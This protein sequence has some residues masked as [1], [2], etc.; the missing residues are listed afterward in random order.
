MAFE[1]PFLL[2]RA[3]IAQIQKVVQEYNNRNYKNVNEPLKRGRW[4][5]R[6]VTFHRVQVI[7]AEDLFAAVDTRTDPS[8]A[9]AKILR[10]VYPTVTPPFNDL[11]LTNET[12]LIVNRFKHI[13][14]DKGTYAK[15][16]FI[17]GEWQLYAA[18]CSVSIPGS[19]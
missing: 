14:V 6:Y 15:A 17:D 12:I 9:T 16:E 10:V 3:A 11:E 4:Q 7:M 1:K 13:S 19:I 18:D 5:G 8:Y 2:T